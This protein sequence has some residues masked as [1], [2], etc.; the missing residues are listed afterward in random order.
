MAIETDELEKKE[1]LK[2]FQ[3]RIRAI[4]SFQ[5]SPGSPQSMKQ[6]IN[7]IR[8]PK[9]YPWTPSQPVNPS[10]YRVGGELPGPGITSSGTGMANFLSTVNII[11]TSVVHAQ[12]I[13]SNIILAV[14]KQFEL[15]H[16]SSPNIAYN[17]TEEMDGR[18]IMQLYC[19]KPDNQRL[20]LFSVSVLMPSFEVK[21]CLSLMMIDAIISGVLNR[22][23]KTEL[24]KDYE[25]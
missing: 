15:E 4:N 2:E 19:I 9:P 20:D 1:T 6:A 5:N 3:D 12:G 7:A 14:N 23:V 17:F 22:I 24:G 8:A 18:H 25:I 13:L 21:E 16:G 10:P 11:P